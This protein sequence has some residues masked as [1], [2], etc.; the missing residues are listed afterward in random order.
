[1]KNTLYQLNS[2]TGGQMNSYIIT[3]ADAKVMVIDGGYRQD[4]EN[5]LA[6]LRE[7][8]G[9]TLPHVDAWIL[10]HA[11][12]DHISCFVEIAEKHWDKLTVGKV[13]FNF[14]SVQYCLQEERWGSD[15][16]AIEEF[17]AVLPVFGDRVVTLYGY[18]EYD[19]GEAHIEVLYSPNAEIQCNYI[20]NSS[21][22]FML[23]LGGTKVLFTGDAGIEEGDRCL[24]LYA[25]SDK[26][27]ADYVQMAHH[28]QNGVEKRFYE[29][30]APRGCLWCTPDW[31]WNN[32]VGG[33][34]NTHV[35]KTVEVREWMAELGARE[36]YVLMN[37]TQVIEL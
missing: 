19:I 6:Y 11:H 31:L 10:S 27:A 3:T 22:I 12:R 26:L 28:G 37:G 5:M 13:M 35:F 30:V 1:M 34:Y 25:G 24:A 8:T 14:P 2:V 20:N 18:D 29:A 15:D 9:E 33:G 32:D 23:T 7:I 16:R 36:H 21:V 4:A 17:M